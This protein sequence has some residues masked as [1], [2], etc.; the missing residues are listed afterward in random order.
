MF[1]YHKF[2]AYTNPNA[3]LLTIPMTMFNP[4]RFHL[5]ETCYPMHCTLHTRAKNFHALSRTMKREFAKG[6]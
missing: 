5:Q 1:F 3:E 4:M 6:K 2:F